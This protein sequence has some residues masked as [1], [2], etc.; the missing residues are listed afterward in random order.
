MDLSESCFW[1]FV[2]CLLRFPVLPAAA[3]AAGGRPRDG[4]PL[5]EG[6]DEAARRLELEL[7][8]FQEDDLEAAK[9]QVVAKRVNDINDTMLLLLLLLLL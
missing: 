4:L 2:R 7:D 8:P 9:R 6:V 5:R 1:F 3:A